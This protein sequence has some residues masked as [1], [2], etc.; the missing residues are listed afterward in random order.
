[1]TC[2]CVLESDCIP[3]T[4]AEWPQREDRSHLPDDEGKWEVACAAVA[5]GGVFVESMSASTSAGFVGGVSG[6]EMTPVVAR[7]VRVHVTG[8]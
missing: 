2:E 1:M 7:V 3:E 5:V 6:G 8:R 4:I